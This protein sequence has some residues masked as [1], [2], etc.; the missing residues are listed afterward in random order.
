M[1]VMADS[2]PAGQL[3][4][5]LIRDHLHMTRLTPYEIILSP[6]AFRR[7]IDYVRKEI[8]LYTLDGYDPTKPSPHEPYKF[9]GYPI[10]VDERATQ[11]VRVAV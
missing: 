8:P 4:I 9:D 6:W 10:R 1:F 3:V 2:P 5:T 7:L 11:H